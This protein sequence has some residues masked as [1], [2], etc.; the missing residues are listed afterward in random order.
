MAKRRQ[1]IIHDHRW[2]RLALR[3]RNNRVKFAVEVMGIQ[4]SWQQ[5]QILEAMDLPGARVSVASGHGTGKS[6]IAG[7][8]F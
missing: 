7:T 2:Q 4:P 8:L 3:Y 6:F 1:S 5:R